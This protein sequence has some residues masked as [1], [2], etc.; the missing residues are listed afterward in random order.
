MSKVE[1]ILIVRWLAIGLS[2]LFVS[3]FYFGPGRP[4][5][6][7]E[8]IRRIRIIVVFLG[9]A[10]CG[11]IIYGKFYARDLVA[12]AGVLAKEN[13]V[14]AAV[15]TYTTALAADTTNTNAY[16]GR[17]TLN[18][19]HG[20]GRNSIQDYTR[21]IGL[22]GGRDPRFYFNRALAYMIAGL[23][24]REIEDL[25]RYISLMPND[26]MAYYYRGTALSLDGKIDL[27]R[28]DLEKSI[29]LDPTFWDSHYNLGNLYVRLG[30]DKRAEEEFTLAQQQNPAD[31]DALVN[32]GNLARA[33]GELNRALKCYTDAIRI[34]PKLAF[35]YF[36]RATVYNSVKNYGGMRQDMD[37]YIEL[38]PND[39]EGYR[40]RA[41]AE[42]FLGQAES[43]AEDSAKAKQLPVIVEVEPP[44]FVPMLPK[45][46]T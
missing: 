35:A 42:F 23:R 10:L 41:A 17:A 27:A 26:A 21:A 45:K 11:S 44:R 22:D 13:D 7:W 2:V 29:Q 24:K 8:S 12:R 4:N 46:P 14:Q 6:S 33:R 39:P 15:S 25:N 40:L 31:G 38:R 19:V 20:E 28:P 43:M 32:L 37:R 36:D 18:L 9:L 3:A 16:S 5:L 30:N 1:L 34:N